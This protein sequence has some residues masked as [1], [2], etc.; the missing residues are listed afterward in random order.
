MYGML[1]LSFVSNFSLIFSA[2][3]LGIRETD[4]QNFVIL[5]SYLSP[6]LGLKDQHNECLEYY[7]HN[8][9]MSYELLSNYRSY[10]KY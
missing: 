2:F 1:Q 9:K 3:L 4:P 5:E 7:T 10:A 8:E 6:F